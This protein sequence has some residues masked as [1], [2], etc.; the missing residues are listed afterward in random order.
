MAGRRAREPDGAG[1]G[2]VYR[3][4][5]PDAGGHRSMISGREDIGEQREVR[6]LCKRLVPIRKLEQVEIGI[7]HE[8]I[9]GLTADPATH[10]HVTVRGTGPRWIDRETDSSLA[11]LAVA[12]AAARNVE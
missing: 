7:R 3:G 4:T 9:F 10:V 12:A 5:R 8:D 6:D 2:D 11:L 1:A